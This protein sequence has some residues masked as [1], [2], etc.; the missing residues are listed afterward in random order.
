M[1]LMRSQT[2]ES[3]W[4]APEFNLTGTDNQEHSLEEFKDKKAVLVVFTCNH[5]PYAIASWPLIIGLYQ[6][7]H[8]HI[9]FI[10]INPNDPDS[11]PDDSFEQMQAKVKEWNI[12]F[13][14]VV[15]KTQETAKAYQAQCT[16]DPFLFVRKDDTWQL[17]YHGRINDNWQ[18]PDK[19]TE[20][21][22]E[23]SMHLLLEEKPAPDNQPSSMGCSI[24]WK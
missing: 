21:N 16:P 2:Q 15:D 17:Y 6:Q 13:P 10:A 20:K 23:S 8:E 7:F 11:Y 12:P 18:E 24:K 9:G 5:C 22:L 14:Y 19:A 1:T 3:G 4:L